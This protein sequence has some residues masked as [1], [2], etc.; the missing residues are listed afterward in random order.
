MLEPAVLK[1]TQGTPLLESR[2]RIPTRTVTYLSEVSFQRGLLYYPRDASFLNNYIM[3]KSRFSLQTF[4]TI[5]SVA[6]EEENVGSAQV[7]RADCN[8]LSW[9][10]STYCSIISL[11]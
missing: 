2:L 3:T 6:S 7:P 8:Y 4:Y 5:L 9:Q 1:F 11:C 10:F